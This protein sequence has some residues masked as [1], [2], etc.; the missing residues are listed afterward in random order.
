MSGVDHLIVGAGTA[1]AILAARLSED[2]ARRVLVLEAGSDYPDEAALPE[3]LRDS[4]KTPFGSHDWNL[5]ATICGERQGLVPRGKVVGGSSQ[6]NGAGVVRAPAADFDAWAALG[7]PA[8]SWER[9]LPS[10]C[11]LEADQQFGDRW[12]HGSAGAIPITRWSREQLL[13]SMAGFLDATL[14]AGHPFC[15]DLNSPEA[16]GIGL[17]PQNRRGRLRIS[18]NLAYLSPSRAR[19]NLTV[20]GGVTVDRVVVR[21]GRAVGVEAGGEMIAGREVILCAGAPFSPALLLRSGIGPAEDLRRA[22]VLPLVDLPGVGT[23]LIDQPGAVIPVVPTT[24]AAEAADSPTLQLV[25]RLAAFPGHTPDYAFYLCLFAG[26]DLVN[27]PNPA[28]AAMLGTPVANLVMVGDMQIASRGRVVLRSPDP[29]ESPSVDLRFY[30]AEGDLDRMRAAYRHAWEIANHAAF[31]ATIAR[32]ALVDD[33]LVADDDRL[34][35]LLRMG[36]QS[37]TSLLGGCPM[38]PEGDP[39]AVVDE[40][41]RVRDV[42]GLR[43]VDASIVPLAL[44]TVPALTCMMLGEH[45]ASWVAAGA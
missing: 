34:D 8:W 30:T 16:I 28:L 10:Y 20:R 12:Y 31:T 7:L 44:R 2:P 45:V 25:A 43:V 17:Y 35:D 40:H 4:Y 41:C 42:E 21:G 22:G 15:E 13:P 38:G 9:V 29:A 33:D 18:T 14:A 32:F 36:T 26:V 39:L 37:R 3:P 24:G 6:T 5:Q 27:G 23:G 11:R 19:P 1:G